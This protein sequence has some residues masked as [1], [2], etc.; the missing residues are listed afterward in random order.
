VG[1]I[2]KIVASYHSWDLESGTGHLTIA[3]HLVK[4]EAVSWDL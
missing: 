3:K 4:S 1:H 2:G